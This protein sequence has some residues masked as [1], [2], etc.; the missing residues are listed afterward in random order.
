MGKKE[1]KEQ[2]IK[3]N[4]ENKDI[5]GFEWNFPVDTQYECL[6]VCED[7]NR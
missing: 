6:S 5:A 3:S 4:L 1:E 2:D 7:L